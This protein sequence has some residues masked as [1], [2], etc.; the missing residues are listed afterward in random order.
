M[1]THI[2]D[3]ML[4]QYLD[5]DLPWS[6]RQRV[7]DHIK[8]CHACRRRLEELRHAEH[9]LRSM[10]AFD[11]PAEFTHRIMTQ[12]RKTTPGV[13][14]MRSAVL[15]FTRVVMALGCVLLIIVAWEA[16]AFGETF[17]PIGDIY[18]WSMTLLVALWS[19]PYIIVETISSQ[20]SEALT[21]ANTLAETV[22]P[23]ALALIALG[24]FLH[25]IRRLIGDTYRMPTTSAG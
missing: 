1:N 9:A 21:T 5:G 20:G 10:A 12:V 8:S 2:N 18:T 3:E 14:W 24:L 13:W 6:E 25:M 23:L 16:W 7:R 17:P 19:N 11:V 22:I 15:R 4:H